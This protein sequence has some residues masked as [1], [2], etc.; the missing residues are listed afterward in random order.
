MDQVRGHS[1]CSV[2]SAGQSDSP[3]IPQHLSLLPPP[4]PVAQSDP[5]LRVEEAVQQGDEEAL[6]EKRGG[7][8]LG[9]SAACPAL[10]S[11]LG[12]DQTGPE[13]GEGVSQETVRG[14]VQ[15]HQ[16]GDAQQGDQ[17]QQ[18]L[19]RLVVLPGLCA[20]G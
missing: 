18:G 9:S 3:P 4:V 2:G 1:G 8:G 10:P 20:V 7:L 17:H 13:E 5:H 6:Q 19:G 11:Y 12:A 14:R 16:V 15:Q